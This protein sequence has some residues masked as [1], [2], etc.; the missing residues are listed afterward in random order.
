MAETTAVYRK[1][2]L[3]A[4]D[5]PGARESLC[6]LLRIDRHTVVSAVN[7]KQALALFTQQSFDLVIVDYAMPEMQGNELAQ[8][9]RLLAPTQPILMVTAYFEKVVDSHIPVDAILS[10]PYGIDD[11]R[12]E[13]A[14]LLGSTSVA[15]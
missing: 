11:L 14:K 10:K 13:I 1:R 3:V 4:E 15:S 8:N 9:I 7:G 2:I 6:L 12:R 5:D